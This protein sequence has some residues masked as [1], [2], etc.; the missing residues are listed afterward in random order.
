MIKRWVLSGTIIFCL[1]ALLPAADISVGFSISRGWGISD[2]FEDVERTLVSDG[3]TFVEKED[4][5][6]GYGFSV[7]L[8]VPVIGNLAVQPEFSVHIGNKHYEFLEV[9]GGGTAGGNGTTG[10]YGFW[11]RSGGVNLV[12]SLLKFSGGWNVNC[13]AGIHSNYF[14]SDSAARLDIDR[15]WGFKGGLGF[16]FRALDHFA[17]GIRGYINRSFD[18]PRISYLSTEVGIYYIL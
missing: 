3:R 10:E 1:T 4:Q 7:S 16:A 9:T 15:F 13:F 2:F 12:Y 18:T 11:I 8:V 14:S 5:Q 17:F 6:M